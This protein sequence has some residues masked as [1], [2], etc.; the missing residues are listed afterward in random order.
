VG[1]VVLAVMASACTGGSSPTPS[2]SDAVAAAEARVAAAQQD[3]TDSK[4][5]LQ[6]ANANFCG[7]AKDYV[8]AIDRYGQLF[9]QQAATVGDV[10]TL[11]ADLAE[12]RASTEAA[13]QAVVDARAALTTAKQELSDAKAALAAA[14]ASASGHPST[15]PES[16]PPSPLPTLPTASIDRVKKAEADLRAASVSITEQTPVVEAG[17]RYTSAAF[18]LEVAWLNLF[19]DAGC[20]TDEQAQQMATA[21]R[22]YTKELQQNLLAAGYYQAEVDGVYGPQT[23]AAVEQLQKDA[24]LPVT[25]L[26]DQATSKALDVGVQE[27]NGAAAAQAST[28]TTAVQT[29]LKLAGYWTGPIDGNWTPELT[30]ALKKFQVAL[31]VEPTG[32]VDAATLAALERALNQPPP[33]TPP[34]TSAPPATTGPTSAPP[35]AAATTGPTQ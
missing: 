11:G 34:A 17:E 14:K 6:Q 1:A 29:A 5:A 27:A 16:K 24:G 33:T 28:Q 20:L 32:A 7:E 3:V 31:G 35:T 8:T 10:Q 9:E 12:P 23:V 18:A 19:A 26:V 21:V 4:A 25:G 13:A 15:T 30:T 2:P 22:T